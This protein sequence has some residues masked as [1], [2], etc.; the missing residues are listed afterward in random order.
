MDFKLIETGNGGDLVFEGGDIRLTA[1]VYNQPYIARFGGNTEASSTDQFNEG[2]ERG[3]WWG[4]DLLLANVPNDQLN[5]KFERS[6]NEIELS[7]SGRIKLEQVAA[8][9]LD[10][11][12]GFSDRESSIKI[13]TV[14]KIQLNDKISQGGNRS[15]EYLW[16]EAKDE[17]LAE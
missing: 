3:D 8:A 1:E 17:I 13:T 6:L 11:L 7:S 14:D 4:N 5:S 16:T 12:E 9:D 10:Y 2:D 15:F